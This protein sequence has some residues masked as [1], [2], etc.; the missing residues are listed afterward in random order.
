MG[1]DVSGWREVYAEEDG[2][3]TQTS[4]ISYRIKEDN[5]VIIDIV[6]TELDNGSTYTITFDYYYIPTSDFVETFLS[7]DV[8]HMT[9]HAIGMIAYEKI[10]D[11]E[12]E[13]IMQKRF[14]QSKRTV[15]NGLDYYA[16]SCRKSNW[17]F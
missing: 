2:V 5:I 4:A 8:Y 11:F 16:E 3:S 15:T 9:K 14:D 6:P 17:D 1:M 12:K 10:R 13:A 7:G